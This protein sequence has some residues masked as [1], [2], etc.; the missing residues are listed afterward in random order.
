MAIKLI[1]IDIDGTLIN[2]KHQITPE[3][4]EALQKAR[5]QG[6]KVVLCTGRPLPG[7]TEEIVDFEGEKVFASLDDLLTECEIYADETV[8]TQANYLLADCV[9]LAENY[10]N[11]NLASFEQVQ[12]VDLRLV[13]SGESFASV[14]FIHIKTGYTVQTNNCRCNV[15][16]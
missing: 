2:D 11:V 8:L 9:F 10:Q 5:E 16:S 7:A 13:H 14:F 6:V 4:H 1:A 15:L 12:F 3:V